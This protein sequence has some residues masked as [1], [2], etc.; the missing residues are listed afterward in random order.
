MLCP[1]SP[2]GRSAGCGG[3][4]CVW[5]DSPLFSLFFF[6]HVLFSPFLGS[7]VWSANVLGALGCALSPV[8]ALRAPLVPLLAPVHPCPQWFGAGCLWE[9]VSGGRGG[10]G[11]ESHVAQMERGSFLRCRAFSCRT[12][13][14]AMS[15]SPL[16]P[17]PPIAP[18]SVRRTRVV[19]PMAAP[20]LS[21]EAVRGRC[22][23]FC[24]LASLP[25]CADG[26]LSIVCPTQP[27]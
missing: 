24:S 14:H 15:P 16:L 21:F 8:F 25:P 4:V 23:G 20:A 5:W 10:C 19:Y 7:P 22:F 6:G 11:G 2:W 1:G 3:A 18:S 12:R 9:G 27:A 13:L 17:L 26:G